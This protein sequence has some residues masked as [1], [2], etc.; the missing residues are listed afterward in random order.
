ML[1]FGAPNGKMRMLSPKNMRVK[2][3]AYFRPNMS[4]MNPEAIFIIM[5]IEFAKELVFVYKFVA[6]IVFKL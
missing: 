2:N 1:S 5:L 3:R 4:K 6:Y